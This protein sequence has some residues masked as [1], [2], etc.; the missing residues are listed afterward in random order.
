MRGHF[1]HE[2]TRLVEEFLA[3]REQPPPMSS[4]VS[5]P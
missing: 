5:A 3:R 1:A 4:I 2:L